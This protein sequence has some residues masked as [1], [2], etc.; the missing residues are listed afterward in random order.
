MTNHRRFILPQAP[1]KEAGGASFLPAV[2]RLL[3]QEQGKQKSQLNDWEDEG[4]SLAG[5]PAVAPRSSRLNRVSQSRTVALKMARLTQ[6]DLPNG[7]LLAERLYQAIALAHL[8]R[9][10]HR[11][12]IPPWR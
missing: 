11:H 9:A 1:I 8:L 10:R 5:A 6:Y 3:N 2:E 7:T 4:G 12:G